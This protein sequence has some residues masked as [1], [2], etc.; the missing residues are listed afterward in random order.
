MAS[1]LN[2]PTS[3]YEEAT[4]SALAPQKGEAPVQR[5]ADELQELDAPIAS[6]AV[7]PGAG[8][9]EGA[10]ETTAGRDAPFNELT[11]DLLNLL[12][13]EMDAAPAEQQQEHG[14]SDPVTSEN[15]VDA[16]AQGSPTDTHLQTSAAARNEL[17]QLLASDMQDL[18]PAEAAFGSDKPITTTP[19]GNNDDGTSPSAPPDAGAATPEPVVKT[20]IAEEGATPASAAFP[21]VGDDNAAASDLASTAASLLSAASRMRNVLK[22]ASQTSSPQAGS[23]AEHSAQSATAQRKRSNAAKGQ[24]SRGNAFAATSAATNPDSSGTSGQAPSFYGQ[25]G[26]TAAEP[27]S[28]SAPPPPDASTLE[29]LVT[30]GLPEEL[31]EKISKFKIQKPVT[32]SGKPVAGGAALPSKA[33]AAAAGNGDQ[34]EESTASADERAAGA[35]QEEVEGGEGALNSCT[36]FLVSIFILLQLLYTPSEGTQLLLSGRTDKSGCTLL[37]LAVMRCLVIGNLIT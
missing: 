32:V 7:S 29:Q 3:S 19:E 37:S 31:A 23:L 5:S 25:P 21:S 2:S 4:D 6:A 20:P 27:S 17:L 10:T 1:Q 30:P 16:A 12:E 33:Q 11:S 13:Q 8:S 36:L 28:S 9:A 35:G 14:H 22:S 34:Q 15:A 26:A 24:A 18:A